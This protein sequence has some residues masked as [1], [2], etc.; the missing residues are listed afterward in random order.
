VGVHHSTTSIVA[1][2]EGVPA[3]AG[4]VLVL[5][6]LWRPFHAGVGLFVTMCDRS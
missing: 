6:L 5:V 3:L 2:E 4:Q 1:A